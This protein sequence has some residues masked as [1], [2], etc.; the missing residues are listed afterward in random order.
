MGNPA[1]THSDLLALCQK[2]GSELKTAAGIDGVTLMAAFA[3]SESTFGYNTTPRH[4]PAYDYGGFYSSHAQQAALLQKYGSAAASSYGPW[5]T[6][7]CNAMGIAPAL[8]NS[9]PDVAASAFVADFNHRVA[10]RGKTLSDYGQIYN[11]G[12]I[13][14]NPLPG[15]LRYVQDLEANYAVWAK[16]LEASDDPPA[17]A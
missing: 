4:E 15:V 6:L 8:L 10:P 1:I 7:P 13:A 14:T 3:Q 9:S 5:Q 17:I 11:G 2:Y 12:H 16:A